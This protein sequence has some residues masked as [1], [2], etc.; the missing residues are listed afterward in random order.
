MRLIERVMTP[1]MRQTSGRN[2]PNSIEYTK[3]Q[4]VKDHAP[5]HSG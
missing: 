5:K 4:V 2:F 3:Q 1:W